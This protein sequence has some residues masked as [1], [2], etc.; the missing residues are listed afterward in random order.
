MELMVP[1]IR[2]CIDS[3]TV[4][5][6]CMQV[7]CTVTGNDLDGVIETLNAPKKSRRAD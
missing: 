4:T 6:G 7:K 3:L 2:R 5:V 1:E